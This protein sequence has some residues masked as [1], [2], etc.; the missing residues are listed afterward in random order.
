MKED[1]IDKLFNGL[2]GKFD[3]HEPE[4][5]HEQRFLDKL[6]ASKGVV[7]LAPRKSRTWLKY[8]TVAAAI[9]LLFSVSYLQLNMPNTVDEQVAIISPEA[10]KTQFYFAGL[11]EEQVKELKSE[12][13]PETEKIIKDTMA[14]LKKLEL[15][16]SKMEQDLVNG[17]NS[18]L[19]LS[20]M[21]TNFQTRIDLLNEVMIQI[22]TIKTLKNKNNAN[23]TI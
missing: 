1:T 7:R 17:G 9:A 2:Q 20:A 19:I 13:S 5:G 23:Y 16:Y 15:N 4:Q 22:E 18:K 21:I 6:N 10:S 12:A 3:T 11:I 14:Q 8:G